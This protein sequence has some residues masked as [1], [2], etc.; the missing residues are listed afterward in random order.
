MVASVYVFFLFFWAY[1]VIPHL[2]LTW[3]DNELGWRPDKGLV[4]PK[5]PFSG[6]E[7]V[8]E[9]LLPFSINYET[10]NHIVAV[11]IYGVLFGGM[12]VMWA[13]WQKRGDVKPGD[14]VVKSRY[15]RPLVKEGA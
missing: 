5:L 9:Y 15:G 13:K 2:W 6:D 8:F 10:I 11:V 14:D 3:A 12:V 1:G 4:G 7:G